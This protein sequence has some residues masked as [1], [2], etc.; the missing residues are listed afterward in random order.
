MRFELLG[1]GKVKVV[2]ALPLL[3]LLFLLLPPLQPKVRA[4]SPPIL[5]LSA[6]LRLLIDVLV[7]CWSRRTKTTKA[8]RR[9]CHS[10]SKCDL[11]WHQI[12]TAWSSSINL[13]VEVELA[14]CVF[15]ADKRGFKLRHGINMPPTTSKFRGSNVKCL[16]LLFLSQPPVL[17]F[18]EA[19]DHDRNEHKNRSKDPGKYDRRLARAILIPCN[20]GRRNW[21]SAV[22]SFVGER[23]HAAIDGVA[24][25]VV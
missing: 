11:G 2:V 3:L 13:V 6:P 16:S 10:W 22:W 8:T 23:A 25:V 5:R 21:P 9:H 7:R 15:A 17:S 19:N 14:C 18:Q 4:W 12:P 20:W 24:D 1:S